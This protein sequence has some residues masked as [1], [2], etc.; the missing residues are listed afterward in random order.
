MN[1]LLGRVGLRGVSGTRSQE[2]QLIQLGLKTET[3]DY[4]KGTGPDRVEGRITHSDSRK[5]GTSQH[6]A[7]WT[8]N[9]CST[10][11]CWLH[12]ANTGPA[13]AHA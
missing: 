11:R 8:R 9:P 13:W 12:G 6:R 4:G 1:G 7:S 3:K 2:P 5:E 10:F